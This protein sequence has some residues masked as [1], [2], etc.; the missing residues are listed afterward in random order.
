MTV[1]ANKDVK[2]YMSE[3]A[4]LQW[5]KF[6]PEERSK[7]MAE[8]RKKGTKDRW[9]G[10]TMA[11]KKAHSAKMLKAKR[12]KQQVKEDIEKAIKYGKLR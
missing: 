12:T 8:L 7:R 11:E 3:I 4:R 1:K 6:T 10:K 9:A 2:S 5:A